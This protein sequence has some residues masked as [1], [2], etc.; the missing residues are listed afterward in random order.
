MT[1]RGPDPMN[2]SATA[3]STNGSSMSIR[4][5]I[6]VTGMRATSAALAT[7]KA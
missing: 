4:R 3:K 1:V 2:G 7:S 5:N 6:V